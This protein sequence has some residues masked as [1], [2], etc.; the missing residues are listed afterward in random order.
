MLASK[1]HHHQPT[2]YLMYHFSLK[3]LKKISSSS[4]SWCSN[5]CLCWWH[6]TEAIFLLSWKLSWNFSGATC[7]A[8]ALIHMAM[9]TCACLNVYKRDFYLNTMLMDFNSALIM[10]WMYTLQRLAGPGLTPTTHAT[11]SCWVW[12]GDILRCSASQAAGIW[13]NGTSLWNLGKT[14]I[15][16]KMERTGLKISILFTHITQYLDQ[17]CF[18]HTPDFLQEKTWRKSQ[19][20]GLEVGFFPVSIQSQEGKTPVLCAKWI[21]SQFSLLG[22]ESAQGSSSYWLH[23]AAGERQFSC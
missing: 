20:E 22:G 6:H 18:C 23:N 3:I 12:N 11:R 5:I 16:V 14:W 4:S 7:S 13:W 21:K 9:C 1:T 10:L 2:S 19:P 17:G 15:S 8:R